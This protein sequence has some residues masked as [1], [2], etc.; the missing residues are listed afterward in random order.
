[1]D[2]IR[3]TKNARVRE[4]KALQSKS[5]LRRGKRLIVLEGDRLIEDALRQGG[6]ASYALYAPEA[7]EYHLIA[8]LQNA[9]CQPL[10]A[11]QAVLRHASE[12]QQP[13]GILAVFHLPK[14]AIPEPVER[15]L[16]LDGIRE[17]GNLGAILRSAAAAAVDIA[18]L[19][20]GNA[21]PYNAKAL[22][23]G[24][25]A[26]FRLPLVE[27]PWKEIRSF[28]QG[29]AV[30]AASAEASVEYTAV[31]WRVPWALIVGNEAHG[32]SAAAQK[33]AGARIA[34]P[35]ARATESLNVASAAAVILFEAR[36]QRHAAD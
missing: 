36:R 33:L 16:I 15:A 11:S 26:H 35:L 24:M 28:C 6:R 30:Y 8:A 3:S 34:I 5:R 18:I 23:G 9:G 19:A 25:G 27:A 13:P 22:R 10:P 17:P 31:D 21:D 20:P 7:A 1:M 2:P 29:L 12:T 4:I 14:P 32:I